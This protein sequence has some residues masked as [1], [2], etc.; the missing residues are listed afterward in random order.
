MW[1]K[2]DNGSDVNW[3]QATDYCRNLQLAGHSDWRLAT[4]N[5]LQGIYD[6]NANVNGWHVR[7]DLQLSGWHWSDPQRTAPQG[8][9]S[10]T[11]L[12]FYFSNG[13]RG[14][15]SL[16]YGF[17]GRALCVRRSGGEGNTTAT[18]PAP[19]QKIPKKIIISAG[20]AGGLLIRATPPIYPPIAKAARV[21]GTV[22]LKIIISK[23]GSVEEVHVVS[24]PAMLQQ[25]AV[26][27]VKQWRYTPYL[28]NG[29]PVEV[30]TTANVAF[31]L[32]G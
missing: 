24:G 32:G 19:A 11:A 23:S 8:D 6:P 31:T 10:G 27:A 21:F 15:F 20:V 16:S 2:K 17:N 26:D 14:P 13:T 18:K 1:T 12:G 7:G 25:A 5:E 29:E 30:E 4:I 28:L 22:E 3:Q 9:L